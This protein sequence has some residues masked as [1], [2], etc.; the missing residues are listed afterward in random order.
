V[1][2]PYPFLVVRTRFHDGGIVSQHR[3]HEAAERA[4]RRWRRIGKCTCGYCTVVAAEEYDSLPWSHK[5]GDA[6]EVTR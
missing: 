4:A 6:H 5:R 3:T 2:A 1:S